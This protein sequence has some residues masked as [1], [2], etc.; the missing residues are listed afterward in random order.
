M[1]DPGG[2]HCSSNRQPAVACLRRGN[3]ELSLKSEVF[4]GIAGKSTE[5]LGK[6]SNTEI[7][8]LNSVESCPRNAGL[9]GPSSLL[10]E[11][12]IV[13]Q[14]A[15]KSLINATSL[16]DSE[17]SLEASANSPA[18]RSFFTAT[19]VPCQP[20]RKTWPGVSDKIPRDPGLPNKKR[21]KA[22]TSAKALSR[23]EQPSSAWPAQ[24]KATK[25]NWHECASL[26]K[27]QASIQSMARTKRNQ[28]KPA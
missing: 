26:V 24:N 3:A 11:F 23:T 19:S 4:F 12:G 2:F 20:A 8:R 10:R 16:G 25:A 21:T 27:N 15:A 9:F 1:A 22:G 6:R 17:S 28:G 13:G 18:L 5:A 14:I 7:S